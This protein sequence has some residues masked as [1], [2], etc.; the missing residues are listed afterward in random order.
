MPLKYLYWNDKIR[1]CT[2]DGQLP[3]LMQ[4]VGWMDWEQPC[5]EGLGCADGWRTEHELWQCVLATQKANHIQ[6]VIKSNVA[7][8]LN[9]VILP[10]LLCSHEMSPVSPSF[11]G[12]SSRQ[13]WTCKSKHRIGLPVQNISCE[14]ELRQLELLSLEK[15]RLWGHLNV[16]FPCLKVFI[17]KVVEDFFY[18]GV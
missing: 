13:T 2:W 1:S 9:E 16:A 17:R 15:K 10:P 12:P 6:V 8:R 7:S 18:P 3:V 11:E 4:A 5:R 14:E